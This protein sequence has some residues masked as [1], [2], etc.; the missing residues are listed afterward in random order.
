LTRAKPEER[1]L[2]YAARTVRSVPLDAR[3]YPSTPFN[4]EPHP[5]PDW[6]CQGS[7]GGLHIHYRVGRIDI[8]VAR[9]PVAEVE[10]NW[11]DPFN[12]RVFAKGWLAGIEDL[13]DENQVFVGS[14][15]KGG[16]RLEGWSTLNQAFAP[17]LMA[18]KG[19][20]INCPTCG[21]Y[22]MTLWGPTFFTGPNVLGRP[23]I[24]NSYGV[25]V[26]E[27]LALSRDLRRPA[28]GFKPIP[29]RHRPS[30][31]EHRI[32]DLHTGAAVSLREDL[33]GVASTPPSHGR[34]L[35]P[36]VGGRPK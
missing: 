30:L 17:P 27:D 15:Y 14:L 3:A 16:R 28:G 20:A 36:R 21:M 7:N 1:W 35:P 10:I 31:G 24:V 2:L 18:R 13:I 29:I 23:L 19:G 32:I 12:V 8:D 22:W 26:R 11:S 9:R 4:G 5:K 33:A 25:F 6:V 34:N